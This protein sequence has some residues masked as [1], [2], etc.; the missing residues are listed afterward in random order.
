MEYS[1][2]RRESFK[3]NPFLALKDIFKKYRRENLNQSLPFTSGGVGYFSY[4]LKAFTEKLP[5]SAIDDLGIPDCIFGF[6][7][8]VIIH[9]NENG[10]YYL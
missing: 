4:D 6:Y 3:A 5:D 7:D 8:A 1:D 10:K 9:D 2:G